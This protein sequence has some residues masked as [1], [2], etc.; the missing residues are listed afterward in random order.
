MDKKIVRFGKIRDLIWRLLAE[1][2]DADGRTIEFLR[3]EMHRM[4]P[5][6]M[7]TCTPYSLCVVMD[8][9]D[10]RIDPFPEALLEDKRTHLMIVRHYDDRDCWDAVLEQDALYG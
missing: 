10:Y 5:Y 3:E 1:G 6:C 2:E 4:Y 9:R 7:F 8:R